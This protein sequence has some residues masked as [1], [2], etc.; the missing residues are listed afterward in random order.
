[1]RIPSYLLSG[2]HCL[3][4]QQILIIYGYT[5]SFAVLFSHILLLPI[6]PLKSSNLF[7]ELKCNIYLNSFSYNYPQTIQ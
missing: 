4:V 7:L 6:L 1:M 3:G 2:R 5:K